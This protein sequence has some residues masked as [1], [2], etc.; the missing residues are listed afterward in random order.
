[1]AKWL[2]GVI[3]VVGLLGGVLLDDLAQGRGDIHVNG[4]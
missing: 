2:G 1:V 3:L 4:G